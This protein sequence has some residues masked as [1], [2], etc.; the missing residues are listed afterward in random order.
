LGKQVGPAYKKEILDD[1]N[2]NN[3]SNS[4][5][6][7]TVKIRVVKITAVKKLGDDKYS[8]KEKYWYYPE[9]HI[10]YD[11]DLKYPVGQVEID[12]NGNPIKLQKDVYVIDKMV[13]ITMIK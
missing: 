11:Y 1:V 4:L 7:I 2:M 9:S 8:E 12:K 5:K 6:S 13:P 10:V 3:G